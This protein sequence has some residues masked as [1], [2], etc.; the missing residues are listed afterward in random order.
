MGGKINRGN[1]GC[2]T[3]LDEFNNN[4]KKLIQEFERFKIKIDIYPDYSTKHA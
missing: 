1:E 3:F 2:G 4:I